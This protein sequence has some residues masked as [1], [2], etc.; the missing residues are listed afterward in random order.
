[1]AYKLKTNVI[2]EKTSIQ[3]MAG[4]IVD[5]AEDIAQGL[6]ARGLVEKVEQEATHLWGQGIGNNVRGGK[7]TD[8]QAAKD[9]EA[10]LPTNKEPQLQQQP[11]Q[12]TIPPVEGTVQPAAALP[13][14]QPDPDDSAGEPTSQ[15][16]AD[17]IANDP[18]LNG[19]A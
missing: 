1:M 4:E 11:A 13:P 6:E 16:T 7:P 2:A 18:L 3:H 19:D 12:T 15:P 8:A 10:A 14:A 9:A 17:D 5:L